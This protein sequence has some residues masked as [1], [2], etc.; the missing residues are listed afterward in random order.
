MLWEGA[1]FTVLPDLGGDF[2]WATNV[3]EGGTICG[4]SF[5]SFSQIVAV[6]WDAKTLHITPLPEPPFGAY[7]RVKDVNDQGVAVGEVCLSIECEPG[8]NRAIVWREGAVHDL[9]DLIPPG[10]GW[11][12]FSAEAV[13]ESGEIV[14]IGAQNGFVSPRGFKLTPR[15][16]TSVSDAGPPTF[17][18]ALSPNPTR[19]AG[20]ISWTSATVGDATLSL[21]DVAGRCLASRRLAALPAGLSR[22]S[23]ASLAPSPLASG[24][25]L[26]ELRREN[27]GV[28]TTRVT[29]VR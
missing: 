20:E 13:N 26:L 27:G 17:S 22:A 9:N 4:G 16:A 3:S 19:G 25:Y 23:L 7:A 29:L 24:I 8:D 18:L 1:S 12:I 2:A 15:A 6:L 10:S 21:F 5:D 28:E 14:C 11:T